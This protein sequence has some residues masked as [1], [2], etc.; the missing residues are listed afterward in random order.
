[1]ARIVHTYE[2]PTG[3]LEMGGYVKARSPQTGREITGTVTEIIES[4]PGATVKVKGWRSGKVRSFSA[5][6]VRPS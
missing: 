5:R 2:T 3:A 6:N 4:G 1:M